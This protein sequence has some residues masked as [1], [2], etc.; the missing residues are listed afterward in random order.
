MEV[1][2]ARH[3]VSRANDKDSPAFGSAEAALLPAGEQ[4]ATDM[5]VEFSDKYSI[6][7][8]SIGVAVSRLRRAQQSARCAGFIKLTI[9][10]LLDEVTTKMSQDELYDCLTNKYVPRAS[11]EA[12][13]KLLATPPEQTVWITHGLV[14][15]GLCEVLGVPNEHRFIPRFCEIRQLTL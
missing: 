6:I 5:G 7:P 8:E 2:V 15:A 13:E 14:I 3:G 11:I 9:T 10:P 1:Y 4:Q 12:A